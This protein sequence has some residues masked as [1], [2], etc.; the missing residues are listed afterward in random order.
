MN[1]D[2]DDENEDIVSYVRAVQAKRRGINDFFD[3]HDKSMKELE[4]VPEAF[5]EAGIT[6]SDLQ[7]QPELNHPPDCQALLDQERVGIEVT[8]LVARE[9]IER[10][11]RDGTVLWKVWSRAAFLR[12]LS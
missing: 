11:K 1:N 12:R 7:K 3:W 10:Y 5:T 6:I 8:E 4:V 2:P 9:V